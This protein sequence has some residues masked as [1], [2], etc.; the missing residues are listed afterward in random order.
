[1]KWLYTFVSKVSYTIGNLQETVNSIEQLIDR[2]TGVKESYA[3]IYVVNPPRHGKSLL[4]D[5]LFLNR[6][7]ICVVE[8]TYNNTTNL[9]FDEVNSR[10]SRLALYYFW[11]RFIHA[12]IPFTQFSLC[13]LSRKVGSF[14]SST[15]YNLLWAK[16]RLKADF[17]MTPFENI[18]GTSKSVL[19]AVDEFSKLIDVNELINKFFSTLLISSLQNEHKVRPFIRFVFTG[20]NRGMTNLMEA[21]STRIEIFSLA[22]CVFSSA[23]PL[24]CAIKNHYDAD[25]NAHKRVLL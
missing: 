13:D 16:D 11:L 6:D 7:D 25:S 9:T 19:I 2:N 18:D 4:L 14:D 22:L 12:V 21:S 1:L 5:R 23:K 8:M 3:F 17:Q 10:S 20:F 24:L 15:N